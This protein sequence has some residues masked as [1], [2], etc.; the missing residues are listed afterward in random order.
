MVIYTL[1]E[2]LLILLY[3]TV[4]GIYLFSCIDII[5]Y[6]LSDTKKLFFKSLIEIVFWLIQIYIAYL[7]SLKLLD[8]YMRMYF[9][10]FIILGVII[11]IKWLKN[12]FNRTINILFKIL[13]RLIIKLRPFI[14]SKTML[15]IF[16]RSIKHYKSIINN[17]IKIKGN[18][19]RRTKK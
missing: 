18:K 15:N 19:K 16:R 4:Y 13:N 5:N 8:G 10:I 6:L 9:L 2:E 3:Y 12:I 14:Y 11:Y 17:N 7:F 1:K